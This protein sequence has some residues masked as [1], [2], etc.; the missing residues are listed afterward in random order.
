MARVT[1]TEGQVIAGVT[2]LEV[3]SWDIDE[4]AADVDV[5]NTG[6]GG[7][8]DSLAGARKV[9]GTV[10]ACWDTAAEP[11][12]AVPGIRAGATVRIR[13]FVGT[14]GGAFWDITNALILS[15]G[16]RSAVNT[17]VTYTFSFTN[18]GAYVRP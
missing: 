8:S 3:R 12:D 5:T 14:A 9:T 13:L 15:V 2:I 6:G 10:E 17:D 4:A 11:T 1:G 16:S 18:Q 7:V